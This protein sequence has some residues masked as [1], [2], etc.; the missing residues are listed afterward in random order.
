MKRKFS[1]E[2]FSCDPM[3]MNSELITS[4]SS[5]SIQDN[6]VVIRNKEVDLPSDLN[7]SVM[8]QRSVG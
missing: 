4:T 3:G 2:S 7:E 1:G 8:P 6:T 5:L